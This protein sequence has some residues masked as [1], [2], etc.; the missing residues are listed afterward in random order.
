MRWLG[1]LSAVFLLCLILLGFAIVLRQGLLPA[2]WTPLPALK[3]DRPLP[4]L[5]DWQ[6]AELKRDRSL[7]QRVISQAEQLV[8]KPIPPKPIRQGCGWT[9]AVRITRAGGAQIG[10]GQI[11][12]EAGAAFAMWVAHDVQPLA[13][14]IFGQ[15]VTAIRNFGTYSCRNMVTDSIWRLQRSQHATANAIDI[16]A[17]RLADGTRIDIK[18][19]WD[20]GDRKSEFL[21]A[22]HLS[23]CRYFR[24][25]LS[26]D[27]N[28]YHYDHFHFDRGN[29]WVC[30]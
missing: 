8:A 7:C 29:G 4:F 17:F 19:H 2:R 18:R 1:L 21:R 16:S 12:C 10:I 13:K 14:M 11:S 6:L 28:R 22:V 15:H 20:A 27:Y 3:I 5:V 23:A 9:N 30:R 25:S 24:V 26:P